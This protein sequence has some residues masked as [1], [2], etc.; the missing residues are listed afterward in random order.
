MLVKLT[1]VHEAPT[2]SADVMTYSPAIIYGALSAAN[3]GV[4][5]EALDVRV[6]LVE[7]I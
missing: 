1:R 4:L 7:V 5:D 2:T 6:T 3:D